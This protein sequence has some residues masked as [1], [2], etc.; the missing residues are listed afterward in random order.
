MPR[1]LMMERVRWKWQKD[2]SSWLGQSVILGW[3]VVIKIKETYWLM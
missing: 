2:V 3:M 1:S